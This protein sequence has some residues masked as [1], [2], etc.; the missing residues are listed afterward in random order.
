MIP[1]TL[2]PTQRAALVAALHT[3]NHSLSRGTGGWWVAIDPKGKPHSFTT[4]TVR[5]L[6]RAWLVDMPDMLAERATLTDKGVAV[7]T[8]IDAPAPQ[9]VMA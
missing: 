6:Q 3:P 4:R 1:A 7:A 2:G 5:M 9:A 8:E